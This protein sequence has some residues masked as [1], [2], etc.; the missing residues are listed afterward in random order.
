MWHSNTE[1]AHAVWG[2]GLGGGLSIVSGLGFS[3]VCCE[4]GQ[5]KVNLLIV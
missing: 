1:V 2:S 5:M 4:G 3:L